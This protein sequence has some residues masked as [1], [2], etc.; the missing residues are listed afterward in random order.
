MITDSYSLNMTSSRW[1][2]IIHVSQY[3]DLGRTMN[4]RPYSE[5][6]TWTTPSN[7]T[8]TLNGTKPYGK[9]FSF[10]GTYSAG[11][12]YDAI[13]SAS[14]INDAVSVAVDRVIRQ[15]ASTIPNDYTT[16]SKQVQTNTNI[17]RLYKR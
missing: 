17:Y 6:G 16:L 4:F 3:D 13:I 14:D 10:N 5:P 8:A 9:A 2:T 11:I 7:A 12:S 1:A 15:L